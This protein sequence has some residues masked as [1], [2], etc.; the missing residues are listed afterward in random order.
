MEAIS[1]A[2]HWI[3]LRGDS[4]TK[5]TNILTGSRSLLQKV[6]N[7]MGSPDW[8][9]THVRTQPSETSVDMP[10]SKRND[11]A[12]GLAGKATTQVGCVSEDLKC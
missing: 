8:H 5:Q 11:R 12:D 10:K 2:L 4:Q 9:M 6:K 3:A 1:L 7:G